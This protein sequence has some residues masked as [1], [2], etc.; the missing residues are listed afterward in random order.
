MIKPSRF[1]FEKKLYA[2]K[3]LEVIEETIWKI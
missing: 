1:Q 3:N 2:K